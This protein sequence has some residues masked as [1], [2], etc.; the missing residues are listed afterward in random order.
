MYVYNREAGNLYLGTSNGEKITINSSGLVG[1]GI[2]L[3]AYKL[4]V[5]GAQN[6]NDIV[7]HNATTGVG[8]RIQSNDGSG[9]I[10]TTGARDLTLGTNNTTRVT[11][12]T[13][14]VKIQE[15]DNAVW[16]GF[17]IGG[18]SHTTRAGMQLLPNTGEIKIGGFTI[19][20]EYPVIYS[21]G[22]A[23]LTFGYGA[24]TLNVNFAGRVTAAEDVVAYSDRR[25]KK[26]IKT[27][28]GSKVY[29]MRGVSFTRIDFPGK[30]GSG[31]IAQEIQKIAPELVIPAEDGTL[32]VA[33]GN[34]TGYLIEAIKDLKAE[35]EELKKHKCDG[36]TR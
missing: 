9:N 21:D 16:R 36:C 30:E 1:I 35:V 29:D 15:T 6:A 31:V 8:L 20:D 7:S 3:P 17:F 14:S 4:Q 23:V 24:N 32:G 28:D 12:G 18:A 11:V 5:S 34:L 22:S 25:L 19:N 27:L 33:Y 26:N 13:G 2:A 10:F